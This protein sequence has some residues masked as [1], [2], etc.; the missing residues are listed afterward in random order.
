[1]D[2][3]NNMVKIERNKHMMC[4][5][6]GLKEVNPPESSWLLPLIHYRMSFLSAMAV[7]VLSVMD[8][9]SFSLGDL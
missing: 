1:M 6:G 5:H 2:S 7:Q 4:L 3:G 9:G 8:L